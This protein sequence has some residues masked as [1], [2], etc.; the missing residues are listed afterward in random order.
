MEQTSC[1]FGLLDGAASQT[2]ISSAALNLS[3]LVVMP[4][5]PT[6]SDFEGTMDTV[7]LVNRPTSRVERIPDWVVVQ[8]NLNAQTNLARQYTTEILPQT[9]EG[10]ILQCQV[11]NRV[12]FQESIERGL[13]VFEHEPGGRAAEEINNITDAIIERAN[14]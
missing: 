9:W 10:N 2:H 12:A 6:I 14:R 7:K 13:T 11:G 5:K 1:E 8:N 4:M 3:D